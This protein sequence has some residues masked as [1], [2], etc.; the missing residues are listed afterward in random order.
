MWL[1]GLVVGWLTSLVG[2]LGLCRAA[3]N[4]DRQLHAHHP[5]LDDDQAWEQLR[6]QLEEPSTW[7][8]ACGD[9]T[10]GGDLF[11]GSACQTA[12]LA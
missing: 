7:C 1:A 8:A 10:L 3:A 5:R 2:V 9:Q 12:W 4:G 6:R 11:C